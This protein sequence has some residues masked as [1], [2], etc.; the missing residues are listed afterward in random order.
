[1]RMSALIVVATIGAIA[2]GCA[3]TQK[4]QYGDGQPLIAEELALEAAKLNLIE[5]RLCLYKVLLNTSGPVC[6]WYVAT[7]P[8]S[9][10]LTIGGSSIGGAGAAPGVDLGAYG[11]GLHADKYGRTFQYRDAFTGQKVLGPVEEDAYG[12]GVHQDRYGRPVERNYNLLD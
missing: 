12:L 9:E 11:P 10:L 1:V 3:G 4:Y 6:D 5:R 2:A 8:S 7:A